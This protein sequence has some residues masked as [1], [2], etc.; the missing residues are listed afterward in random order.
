M[1]AVNVLPDD[2]LRDDVVLVAVVVCVLCA[3]VCCASL[4]YSRHVPPCSWSDLLTRTG[5]TRDARTAARHSRHASAASQSS[6]DL[7]RLSEGDVLVH[8]ELQRVLRALVVAPI[9]LLRGP[10][11]ALLLLV[12]WLLTVAEE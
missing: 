6:S 3:S 9:R 1:Q 2:S 8:R 4:L 7:F 5:L 10:L 11:K 12:R